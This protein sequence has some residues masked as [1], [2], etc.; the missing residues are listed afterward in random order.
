MGCSIK[1]SI[2]PQHSPY[3][4]RFVNKYATALAKRFGINHNA[5]DLET[6]IALVKMVFC[7]VDKDDQN[8]EE[9]LES[10]SECLSAMYE[11]ADS[12]DALHEIIAYGKEAL[13]SMPPKHPKRPGVFHMLSCCL[14]KR[15]LLANE[16]ADIDDAISYA[17]EAIEGTSEEENDKLA[18]HFWLISNCLNFRSSHRRSDLDD[19]SVSFQYAVLYGE[20]SVERT[21]KMGSGA[22]EDLA[23]RLVYLSA[24][25]WANASFGP[26]RRL[27]DLDKAFTAAAEACDL[28]KEMGSSGSNIVPVALAS[29]AQC[30]HSR[31]DRVG[32]WE[33]LK[34]SISLSQEA[35][36]YGAASDEI[37]WKLSSELAYRL[38]LAC[39]HCLD[40]SLP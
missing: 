12:V 23:R 27:E 14:R 11:E 33:D 5:E 19:T 28:A 26:E 36:D 13:Q 16:L 32:S 22:E 18:S 20:E 29:L 38:L 15:W 34:E 8:Y 31:F 10:V 2:T 6:A 40:H 4:P 7:E 21:R 25:Y 9:V 24:C 39:K 3:L 1:G 35:M 37:D 17:W 30:F